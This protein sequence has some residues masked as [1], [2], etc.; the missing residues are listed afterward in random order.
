MKQ[1]LKVNEEH[2]VRF[3]LLGQPRIHVARVDQTIFVGPEKRLTGI[4]LGPVR[5]G[6]R[7]NPLDAEPNVHVLVPEHL[8]VLFQGAEVTFHNEVN[9]LSVLI[10]S[11]FCYVRAAVNFCIGHADKVSVLHVELRIGH[12]QQLESIATDRVCQ[13]TSQVVDAHGGERQAAAIESS[14]RKIRVRVAEGVEHDAVHFTFMPRNE[15]TTQRVYCSQRRD[16]KDTMITLFEICTNIVYRSNKPLLRECTLRLPEDIVDRLFAPLRT[17]GHDRSPELRQQIV[18]SRVFALPLRGSFAVC[19]S[20]CY[21]SVRT[22]TRCDEL[23]LEDFD[24]F[25]LCHAK[26]KNLTH[27]TILRPL[28]DKIVL[29]LG[30]IVLPSLRELRVVFSGVADVYVDTVLELLKTKVVRN[31]EVVSLTGKIL[32]PRCEK[33]IGTIKHRKSRVH[34]LRLQMCGEPGMEIFIL[35]STWCNTIHTLVLEINIKTKYRHCNLPFESVRTLGVMSDP[36]WRLADIMFLCEVHFPFVKKIAAN[37]AMRNNHVGWDWFLDKEH[38]WL[39]EDHPLN[40][41]DP[42]LRKLVEQ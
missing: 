24:V 35:V 14:P 3:A 40:C 20:E 16:C 30:G 36:G 4:I 41:G 39:G 15:K 26:F 22:L 9:V 17:M 11:V 10:V 5:I 28:Q 19:G 25:G 38:L 18:N 31:C 13:P 21:R 27:L 7:W 32:L 1:S 34:T 33:N 42:E 2:V 8:P 37:C 29:N 23:T 6:R 12:V